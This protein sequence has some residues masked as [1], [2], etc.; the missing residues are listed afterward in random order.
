[1]AEWPPVTPPKSGRGCQGL[2]YYLFAI[3]G[4]HWML[5]QDSCVQLAFLQLVFHKALTIISDKFNGRLLS[6]DRTWLFDC[7]GF[8]VIEFFRYILYCHRFAE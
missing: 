6:H 2:R 1:L 7:P 4:Q 5:L 3:I 8:S